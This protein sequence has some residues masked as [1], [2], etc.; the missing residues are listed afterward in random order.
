MVTLGAMEP[1]AGKP[2]RN[3][4]ADTFANRLLLARAFAGHLSIREA[5]ERCGIGRGA[6]T[7]WEK[8][9]KP[10][11]RHEVVEIISAELGVD[12]DWLL[13]GGPLADGT[14]RRSR[15]A[16]DR[17]AGATSTLRYGDRPAPMHALNPGARRPKD[18]RP[19]GRARSARGAVTNSRPV[20]LRRP[21]AA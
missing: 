1:L 3:V 21:N 8:G 18:N 13:N 14:E 12:E 16:R 19:H 10:D 6:W 15:W 17:K 9:A 7:N 11:D 2:P 20:I 4:P 5:A